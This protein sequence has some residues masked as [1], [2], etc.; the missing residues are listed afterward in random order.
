MVTR[1]LLYIMGGLAGAMLGS[2][3]A[4]YLIRSVGLPNM[5]AGAFTGFTIAIFLGIAHM[6]ARTIVE[7]DQKE[8]AALPS[9]PIPTPR[10]PAP[11]PAPCSAWLI[12]TGGGPRVTYPLRKACT[13][14]GRDVENDVMINS[15]SISRS[16][17][18]IV[19][20]EGQWLVLDLDSRNGTFVNGERVS[21]KQLRDGDELV[22]GSVHF[23]VRI[24]DFTGGR[25]EGPPASSRDA[26]ER[27][28]RRDPT[29]P[30]GAETYTYRPADDWAS[31]SGGWASAS[32]GGGRREDAWY[33]EDR[34]R[35]RSPYDPP[36]P[37]EQDRRK[38]WPEDDRGWQG[39][40]RRQDQTP[41]PGEDRR[42]AWPEDWREQERR[43]LDEEERRRRGYPP[44][45]P[46]DDW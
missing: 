35:P 6:L 44:P 27:D 37:P 30:P 43:R 14:I 8:P 7:E 2:G 38:A 21:Q 39:E 19:Q 11:A 31:S 45:P 12:P 3:I 13:L 32:G 16:H 36:Y 17:A 10:A 33:G 25:R 23:R 28:M 29:L 9:L 40:D 5:L 26:R 24:E 15:G 42:R 20:M 22:L 4:L 34:R 18:Q 41:Y 46:P 1:V